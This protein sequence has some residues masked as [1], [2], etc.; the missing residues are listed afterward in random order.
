VL[1]ILKR[2]NLSFVE[3]GVRLFVLKKFDKTETFFTSL[4]KMSK[5][6][7]KS[8]SKEVS[9]FKSIVQDWFAHTLSLFLTHWSSFL[10]SFWFLKSEHKKTSC[11]V[12]FCTRPLGALWW[13]QP[14]WWP[15]PKLSKADLHLESHPDSL[16]HL[17]LGLLQVSAH[18]GGITPGILHHLDLKETQQLPK[19]AG[20]SVN[21]PEL[22]K[23]SEPLCFEPNSKQYP[24]L[25]L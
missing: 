4:Q 19:Y 1:G 7:S 20:L 16:K 14:T 25:G 9:H 18:K 17:A 13:P 5:I 23:I 21:L 8:Q 22:W 3:V 24:D 12:E 10:R 6:F 2:C 15:W 11:L